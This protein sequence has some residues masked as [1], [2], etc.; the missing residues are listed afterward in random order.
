MHTRFSH[1]LTRNL[2]VTLRAGDFCS[3]ARGCCSSEP[4]NPL[5]WSDHYLINFFFCHRGH[6]IVAN[7]HH[8]RFAC[9]SFL[10]N[11]CQRQGLSHEAIELC[12]CA[13]D[14]D[15]KIDELED[16]HQVRSLLQGRSA[17]LFTIFV[18]DYQMQDLADELGW[19][20]EKLFDTRLQEE[21]WMKDDQA[22]DEYND[23][24]HDDD[25]D[26]LRP[27]RI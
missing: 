14:V 9:D 18:V 8:F 13:A 6:Y 3:A 12:Q 15:H 4:T 27:L 11:H 24:I 2:I 10:T 16:L 17:V 26:R 5:Q 7:R 20:V 25:D 21:P 23:D 22:C 1:Y 19:D